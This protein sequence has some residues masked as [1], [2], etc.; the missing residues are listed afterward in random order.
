MSSAGPEPVTLNLHLPSLT[1]GSTI[2]QMTITFG[3][4][5]GQEVKMTSKYY[6]NQWTEILQKN[7]LIF[8]ARSL[9][10]SWDTINAKTY[11]TRTCSVII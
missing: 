6:N 2:H 5:G 4:E 7:D 9:L 3:T 11:S 8:S 10:A 1:Y